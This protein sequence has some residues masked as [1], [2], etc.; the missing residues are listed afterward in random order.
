M[1]NVIQEMPVAYSSRCGYA[2][3]LDGKA[4]ELTIGEDVPNSANARNSLY[5]AAK[6]RGMSVHVYIS[7]DKM[8]VQAYSPNGKGR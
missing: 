8:F 5:I 3:Y 6:R 7:G 1:A 2:Q 4:W